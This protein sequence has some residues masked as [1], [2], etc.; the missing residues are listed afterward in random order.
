MKRETE[1]ERETAFT[2]HTIF[3]FLRRIEKH[4]IFFS[5]EILV[6]WCSNRNPL[7][8]KTHK[9][10]ALWLKL[11][12]NLLPK[13]HLQL[14][15]TYQTTL[16]AHSFISVACEHTNGTILYTHILSIRRSVSA[17]LHVHILNPL[18]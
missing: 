15:T 7:D 14:R 9:L 5:L 8:F 3:L 13:S 6:A 18:Y 4:I 2:V 12:L 16:I 10:H 11:N 1:R 17:L